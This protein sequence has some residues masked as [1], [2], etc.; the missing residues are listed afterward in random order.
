[1]YQQLYVWHLPPPEP[2]AGYIQAGEP[3]RSA[4]FLSPRYNDATSWYSR[5]VH[6]NHH[7]SKQ[8][9]NTGD[10]KCISVAEIRKVFRKIYFSD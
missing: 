2:F 8:P 3:L 5:L 7:R 10:A 6:P 4:T 1:M 9:S